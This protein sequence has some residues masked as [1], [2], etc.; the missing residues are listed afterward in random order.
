MKLALYLLP[1]FGSVLLLIAIVA[2][3]AVQNSSLVSLQFLNFQSVTI[4]F[5]FFLILSLLFG[6]ITGLWGWWVRNP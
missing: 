6:M 5:A 3:V 2:I 4:P 1:F